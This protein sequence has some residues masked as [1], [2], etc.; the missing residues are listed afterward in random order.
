MMKKIAAILVFCCFLV[1]IVN[2]FGTLCNKLKTPLRFPPPTTMP[3]NLQVAFLG[4]AGASDN[5]RKVLQMIKDWDADFVIHSGDFEYEN[6]AELFENNINAVLGEDYPYFACLG[7]H[8]NLVW[9]TLRGHQNRLIARLERANATSNCEGDYGVNMACDYKGLYFVLSGVGTRGSDHEDYIDQAFSARPAVWRVVSWHKNQ[10][11]MQIGGKINEVGWEAYDI[12]R[13]HGAFI[14]TGHEHSYCRSYMMSDYENQEVA[15]FNATLNLQV[16]ES[17]AFVSGLAGVG[18][19]DWNEDL[20]NNEWWAAVGASNNNVQYGALLCTFNLNGELRRAHCTQRDINGVIWDDFDIVSN[21]PDT[22][23]EFQQQLK[24]QKAK[25]AKKC[26]SKFLEIPVTHGNSDLIEDMETGELKCKAEIFSFT[27]K[28]RAALKF[29]NIPLK[30]GE[31]VVHAYLQVYGAT[32]GQTDPS[33]IIS[34]RLGRGL[35]SIHCGSA[36]FQIQRSLELQPEQEKSR[37]SVTWEHE[38]DDWEMQ[39]VWVSPDLGEIVN[40]VVSKEQWQEGGEIVLDI[41]GAGENFR[42]QAR[43]AEQYK[44]FVVEY[45]GSIFTM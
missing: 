24:A 31:K 5:Q 30:Q 32:Q 11:L 39:N 9:A 4:D 34:G 35:R 10:R 2:G 12:A 22:E 13:V 38:D 43:R 23:E 45:L 40:E 3:A 36:P 15:N 26:R 17:F 41:L 44:P 42:W 14:A 16:G 28:S 25:E 18:I 29:E 21:L 20:K 19:R 37:V 33:F 1:S 7:N 27:K 6:D 8:D